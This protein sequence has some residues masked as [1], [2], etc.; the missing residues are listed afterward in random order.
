[1]GQILVRGIPED[2]MEALGERAHRLGRSREQEV[3]ELIAR[4]AAEER[5]WAEHVRRA[6]AWRP[7]LR[8]R[9]LPDTTELLRDDRDRG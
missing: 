3:R 7:R 2:D 4:A 5:G 6:E 9:D 8:D 1:M